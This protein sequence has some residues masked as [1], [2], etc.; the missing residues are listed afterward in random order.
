MTQGWFRRR[1]IA[2]V[3][4]VALHLL[5]LLL[6]L[7]PGP[8][9]PRVARGEQTSVLFFIETPQPPVTTVPPIPSRARQARPTVATEASTPEETS[10]PPTPP[11][12][13]P[14]IDW[15]AQAAN[16]AA[17]I[18]DKA[19]REETRKCDPSDAPNSF[20]PPC[21][22]RTKKFE[23]NPEEP[24]VG[25]SGGLPYVR[26][27]KRCAIGLG[28]FGCALGD[29]PPANGDLFEGMDDP[30]RDRS[31]VPSPHPAPDL[32]R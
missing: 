7:V 26:L 28:F 2:L 12:S 19:I 25:F 27:G 29:P 6:L 21:N 15:A 22:P 18:V 11:S 23:W 4:V 32:Q 20:L 14:T 24:R 10:S 8:S 31:S 17:A 3:V 1:F 5:V 9:A 13:S 30:E 16:A